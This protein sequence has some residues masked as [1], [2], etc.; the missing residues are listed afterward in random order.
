MAG[1]IQPADADLGERLREAV[2]EA[3]EA[4]GTL[5]LT[6][7][8]TK[9]FMGRRATGTALA[10]D[11]HRGVV[12][13]EPTELVLS[14][15]C[16]TP[17]SYIQNVLASQGQMLAFEPP[18]FG[19]AA[20]LGGTVAC[21]LSGPRRPFG[22]ALR[23]SVLGVRVVNGRGEILRFGGEVMKNVAG[24]D[25]SRLMA[26]AMGTLGLLLE[27][28][29]KVL[30]APEEECSVVLQRAQA[31]ALD[32]MAGLARTPLPLSGACWEGGLLRLR[33]SGSRA[34]VRAAVTSVGGDR[35]EEAEATDFWRQ[36]REQVLPFFAGTDPVWRVS[37][38]PACPPLRGQDCLVDWCGGLRWLRG[39]PDPAVIQR[40]A[41][42]R[43]GHASLFRGG[44]RDGEVFH[45]L[46]APLLALHQRIKRA[47]DPAGVFN[48]GRL[49]RDL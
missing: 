13:Y 40:I 25:V 38:P 10:V 18:S 44:D 15:R 19:Q 47:M 39:E 37:V 6:G 31:R 11:G 1:E 32:D 43:G 33:F 17:L 24:Y 7:S 34:G 3:V 49:Y 45:P 8:G 41:A 5:Q 29:L 16:G 35:L 30:P 23:D 46:P 27:V 14:A 4:G 20:T 28:S 26:G 2:R 22:G 48:P 9:H 12:T 42:E 36:L 21:G